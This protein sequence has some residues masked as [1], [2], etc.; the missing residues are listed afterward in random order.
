MS[1]EQRILLLAWIIGFPGSL[2]A[3]ILVWTGPC[4]SKIQWTATVL[5]A[6]SM[7]IGS[8]ILR[9]RLAFSLRTLSNLLAALREGDYSI[10]ARLPAKDDA[11]GEVIREINILG[12]TLRMQRLGALEATTLL[13]KVMAEIDTAVFAFDDARKLRLVNRAGERFLGKPSERILGASAAELGLDD[14]LSGDPSRTFER[15]YEG[16]QSRWSMKRGKFRERGRPHHLLVVSDIGKALREEERQ[17]WQ[18]LVRVLGH[19]LNNSLAPIKSI[20]TSLTQMLATTPDGGELTDD[21]RSGLD[22]I[23]ARADAL[24]RFMDAYSRL[25]RL[26]PPTFKPIHIP[27][28]IKETAELE[29]RINITIQSGPDITIRADR[30][31][32]DQLLINLLR[33]AVDAVAETGGGVT[34]GWTTNEYHVEIFIADRGPGIASTSNLFVPFFT[35]KPSGSGIGLVLSRQ[36]A[37]AHGGSLSLENNPE[38]GCVARL[39]LPLNP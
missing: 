27:S 36:I 35:T 5:I 39:K 9:S 33:N 8:A 11:M 38:G 31:Q 29:T 4:S 2:T 26:P 3:L 23:S 34:T 25:A 21:I 20:S 12:E 1:L 19:E 15:N 6:A 28:W 32:L 16:K 37:E 22:V 18:R 10:R 7:G 24:S 13:R 30:D 14:C 17:A